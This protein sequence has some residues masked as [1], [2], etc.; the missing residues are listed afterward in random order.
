M[1]Y[2]HLTR[3]RADLFDGENDVLSRLFAIFR[4]EV[5]TNCEHLR[6]GIE[7][8][9]AQRVRATAH[10]LCSTTS[11]L[12]ATRMTRLCRE[13]ESQSKAG[14]LEGAD[15]ILLGLQSEL[16]RVVSALDEYFATKPL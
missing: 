5:P 8:G 7:A 6:S 12:G 2:D 3:L 15:R 4:T 9:D 13:L 1:D 16:E 11:S 14:S 10:R